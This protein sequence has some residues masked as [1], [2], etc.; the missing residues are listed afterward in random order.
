LGDYLEELYVLKSFF[1]P[2]LQIFKNGGFEN[3]K[4]QIFF[5]LSFLIP[6]SL[7]KHDFATF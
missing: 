7:C 5:K 1:E 4:F 3:K 2:D 6:K